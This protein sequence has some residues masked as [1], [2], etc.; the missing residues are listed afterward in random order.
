VA[1][2]KEAK[3][4]HRAKPEVRQREREYKKNWNQANRQHINKYMR[5]YYRAR[6]ESGSTTIK[7]SDLFDASNDK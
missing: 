7:Q 1:F 5:D 3:R 2:S 4:A 6:V